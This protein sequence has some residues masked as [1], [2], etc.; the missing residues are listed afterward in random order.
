MTKPEEKELNARRA[1]VAEMEDVLANC[2]LEHATLLAE[3]RSFQRI[4]I[5]TVGC[6]IAQLDELE[7]QIAEVI[8]RKQTV[9]ETSMHSAATA[10]QKAK[11]SAQS[12]ARDNY[13]DLPNNEFTPTEE[14][15]KLFRD[16]AKKI[17]PDL[18]SNNEDRGIRDELMKKANDAYRKGEVE[19]LRLIAE[20]YEA[21][22]ENIEGDSI[23]AQLV[24]VI[25]KIDIVSKHVSEIKGYYSACLSK[26]R[27]LWRKRLKLR[28]FVICSHP[29]YGD[30]LSKLPNDATGWA[31]NIMA[32]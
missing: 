29:K 19:K 25:R 4:Y 21:R 2:E 16:V 31:F 15:K 23:G 5:E 7:A 9:D 27:H 11:E 22:P 13:A 32:E 28:S 1:I 10:R 8:A 26:N 14:I 12:T 3:L 17:H 24:R 6:L 18:A 30:F 20:E